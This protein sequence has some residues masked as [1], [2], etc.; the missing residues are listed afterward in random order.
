MAQG[1]QSRVVLDGLVCLYEDF[2]FMHNNKAWKLPDAISIREKDGKMFKGVRLLA[3]K[4]VAEVNF[5]TFNDM[6]MS[7]LLTRGMY[8]GQQISYADVRKIITHGVDLAVKNLNPKSPTKLDWVSRCCVEY[9]KYINKTRCTNCKSALRPIIHPEDVRRFGSKFSKFTIPEFKKIGCG[10]LVVIQSFGQCVPWRLAL[11]SL[12]DLN[13][14]NILEFV[15]HVAK[16]YWQAGKILLWKHG[17]VKNYMS[18]SPTA[19]FFCYFTGGHGNFVFNYVDDDGNIRNVKFYSD[20]FKE[21]H[22]VGGGIAPFRK[23][24]VRATLLESRRRGKD[25]VDL[26]GVVGC[27]DAVARCRD[28]VLAAKYNRARVE[29]I[30]SL[31]ND[32]EHS[33]AKGLFD[34][35]MDIFNGELGE[36]Y[37]FLTVLKFPKFEAQVNKCLTPALSSLRE[38]ITAEKRLRKANP[39]HS[40]NIGKED[41]NNS[42]ILM[43]MNTSCI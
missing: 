31:D 11:S 33:K 24:C 10:F 6:S 40:V 9:E 2:D 12:C 8:T 17:E 16:D 19:D 7:I 15:V 38:I 4:K 22:R 13:V 39:M 37:R 1:L 35:A 30:V 21:I 42:M 14:E 25:R 27:V 29:A 5:G 41:I 20:M 32:A 23:A 26:D 34:V 18:I 28:N 3:D 43:V 36:A